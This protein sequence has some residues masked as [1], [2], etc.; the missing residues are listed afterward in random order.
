MWACRAAV[1]LIMDRAYEGDETRQLALE[2]GFMPVV[3]PHDPSRSVGVQRLVQATQRDRATVPPTQGL[4]A[5]LLSLREARR[6][7]HGFIN[8]ALIVEA[9]RSVN[10]P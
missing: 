10:R 6:H 4:P 9:L 2:L 1:D 3:P 8:F 7:V 5:H